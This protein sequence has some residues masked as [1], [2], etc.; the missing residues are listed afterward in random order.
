MYREPLH[1][2]LLDELTRLVG[3]PQPVIEEALGRLLETLAS[4]FDP[5]LLAQLGPFPMTAWASLAPELASTRRLWSAVV[6]TG[7]TAEEVFTAFA[8]IDDHVRRR[9]GNDAW[10]RAADWWSALAVQ[11]R[12]A[13]PP[14][15]RTGAKPTL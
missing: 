15:Q 7:L 3:R 4:E 6:G 9:Y 8:V 12:H 1:E 14:V 2:D 5:L 13:A 10:P 11:C